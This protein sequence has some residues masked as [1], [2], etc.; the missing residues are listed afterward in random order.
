MGQ[1]EVLRRDAR[2]VGCFE[3]ECDVL[4]VGFGCAGACAAIEAA[5]AG[6][7]V[8]VVER[9]GGAGGP[10]IN[11]GG[12][13]YLGGGTALQKAL[14]YE[15][16]A[17]NMFRYM[18]AACGPAPDEALIAPYCEGS[19]L[20]FDWIVKQGVPYRASYFPGN[21]EPFTTDDGLTYSGSEH[22]HPFNQIARP[23]PRG[24]APQSIR[25]KG[26]LLMNRLI[27]SALAA[28]AR[29]AYQSRCDQLVIER[30][31]RVSG[32]ILSTLEGERAVRVRKG[33]ILTAG[34]FIYNDAMLARYAPA[35]LRCGSKVG[36]ETDDGLGI[37]LGLAAGGEA[38]RM[39]AGD[40]SMAI[41]PPNRLRSGIFVNQYGQRFL[42]EDVYFGRAGETVLFH[43]D[44]KAY[45]IVDDACFERPTH[46]PIELAG[47]GE[48]I[49]ELES[50]V[51]FPK[52]V[53]Q[54]TVAYYN[55]HAACREDPLFHKLPEWLVPL[56]KPPFAAIDLRAEQPFFTA[57]TLGGLR[58]DAH[59]RVLGASGAPVPG[60]YAAGRTTS[61]VAK[62]GYSSG[63][64]LGDGSF[65]GR[66]A[67]RHAAG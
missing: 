50:E 20:H 59:A 23:A 43:Q 45:H 1:V 25:D 21:H 57:F 48:T 63:M 3:L 7:K 17:E 51:G 15:D 32:A 60:L 22:V 4:V 13:L 53:L 8:L 6:A 12:F 29:P 40:V 36:T 34:G 30:D 52:G 38:I 62:Q 31:G 44:G 26:A 9:S 46:F 47:V 67:G 61:G 11:S 27:A 42:N 64:S 55:E 37:R 24:H 14:G 19:A 10:S 54:A 35:L 41:F 58:I 2:D 28:G 18:M 16:S 65:F 39:E 49:E 56:V 66:R 5:Q 33:V